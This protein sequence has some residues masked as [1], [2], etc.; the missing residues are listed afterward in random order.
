MS[1]QERDSQPEEVTQSTDEQANSAAAGESQDSHKRKRAN[2]ARR[3]NAQKST[4][5]RTPSGKRR[6]ANN[7]Y[8]HGLY[9]ES[10]KR[11]LLALEE[12]PEGFRDQLLALVTD[13]KPVGRA[14]HMIIEHIALL[15]LERQRVLRALWG[16]QQQARE[17]FQL[18]RRRN[19]RGVGSDSY[20]SGTDKEM[21]ERGLANLPE[22]A[23][24]LGQQEEYWNIIREHA[25]QG[26]F[27]Q[28][29]EPLFRAIYGLQPSSRGSSIISLYHD[30]AER[31]RAGNPVRPDDES[32]PDHQRYVLLR[33]LIL[34]EERNL[35][36][37][38]QDYFKRQIDVTPAMLDALLVPESNKYALI[39]R[40]MNS[41]DRQMERKL[42]MLFQLQDRRKAGT[43]GF[44]P[45]P[46]YGEDENAVSS[47]FQPDPAGSAGF[48]PGPEDG[49]DDSL[50]GAPPVEG[51]SQFQSA[52][53]EEE[54]V[55][56]DS[57][58]A[59]ADE[60]DKPTELT[61]SGTV[62]P[63]CDG[64]RCTP[65]LLKANDANNIK[66]EGTK[67]PSSLL[68]AVTHAPNLGSRHGLHLETLHCE[69]RRQSRFQFFHSF[70]DGRCRGSS[71]KVVVAAASAFPRRGLFA[72]KCLRRIR[73]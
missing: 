30:L 14:E 35:M 34:E 29:L 64:P 66:N 50:A 9:V 33:L 70:P 45:S 11:S 46:E 26:D 24:N 40:H 8:Q 1:G 15:E 37:A 36:E 10:V 71:P 44:D 6:V 52:P 60:T 65:P 47:A 17:D 59:P 41:I 22:S 48:E 72:G 73:T 54:D 13:L 42:K 12:N 20:S 23:D 18:D 19:A 43:A 16:L 27:S 49:E 39:L 5:P 28:E 68:S 4:G 7:P 55:T 2:A 69:E 61:Q 31:Q 57:N 62:E 58:P 56:P 25:E 51:G 32:D 38:S 67:L 63:A 3:R 21:L 53:E